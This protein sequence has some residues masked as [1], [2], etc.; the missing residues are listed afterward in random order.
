MREHK[1]FYSYVLCKNMVD[2]HTDELSLENID[3]LVSGDAI[4]ITM[5]TEI[6]DEGF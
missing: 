2:T 5:E 4:I 1:S 3:D 6:D